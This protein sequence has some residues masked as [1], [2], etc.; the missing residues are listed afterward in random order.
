MPNLSQV[1]PQQPFT[2]VHAEEHLPPRNPE[3]DML[4]LRAKWLHEKSRQNGQT[5]T[6]EIY[7]LYR[8]AAAWG[9]EWAAASLV[10]MLQS[11]DVRDMPPGYLQAIQGLRKDL[12]VDLVLRN[13]PHGYFLMG[14]SILGHGSPTALQYLRRA[15]DLGSPEAQHYLGEHRPS[16][17]AHV[18][19]MLR[20]AADQG[21]AEAAFDVARRLQAEKK[22][23]EALHYFHLSAKAGGLLAARYLPHIF[24]EPEPSNS[25]YYLGQDKDEAR[26]AR[27]AKIEEAFSQYKVQFK[28]EEM[29]DIVPLPPAKLPPWEGELLWV[30]QWESNIPPP[31]PSEE[32]IEEMARAK[33]LHPE[34]AYPLPLQR[35]ERAF[36]CSFERDRLPPPHPEAD[37]LFQHASWL[38]KK[39]SEEKAQI[40]R[41]YRIAAAWGHEKAASNLALMFME[42][43]TRMGDR[44]DD[45]EHIGHAE[46]MVDMAEA[47]I[48]RGVP[49]GYTLM[50]FMLQG[51]LLVKP[52][53]ETS[54]RYFQ[55]AAEL[56]EPN[57]QYFMGM[58]EKKKQHNTGEAQ[59]VALS[60]TDMERV[61]CA[62]DQGHAE[63]AWEVAQVLREEKNH[64]LALHYFQAALQAGNAE[65]AR[66]LH[67]AFAGPS[68][69]NPRYMGQAK[70]SERVARYRH[71]AKA[72][73]ATPVYFR[74][75]NHSYIPSYEPY[76]YSHVEMGNFSRPTVDEINRILPLP[77]AQ[78]PPWD[79][80]LL[81]V[82]QWESN[83]PPPLPSEERIEEMARAQGLE[84]KTGWPLEKTPPN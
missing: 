30:K 3:A 22:Y 66:A 12:V 10:K 63:A 79:G 14:T 5:G 35:E 81:W 11:G 34:T 67:D 44:L 8:I 55:K 6:H 80:K 18:Q 43:R 26:A 4:F 74:T 62:A 27:Y 60:K 49:L 41:L 52:D 20:C 45:A 47:L 78:L 84:A 7:R 76:G 56:G 1:L 77:P 75:Y 72:L 59:A 50:G 29:D 42:E 17:V 70:D 46:Q 64:A 19:E 83:I 9:H 23:Q 37:M 40:Q 33:G 69:D 51:S 71:I 82:K 68:P 24:M 15:A 53:I 54:L 65:A 58:V 36:T 38:S 61:R 48:R 28:V 13:I 39:S 57:A 21:H 25:W 2:C 32:R 31:L 16:F 73:R